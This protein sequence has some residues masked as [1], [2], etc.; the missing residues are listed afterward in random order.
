MEQYEE[1]QEN[2]EMHLPYWQ[3]RSYRSYKQIKVLQPKLDT[4]I[5]DYI[6]IKI[7]EQERKLVGGAL[8]LKKKLKAID[9]LPHNGIMSDMVSLVNKRSTRKTNSN[10]VVP[11]GVTTSDA[12]PGWISGSMSQQELV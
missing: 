5:E 11:G 7:D 9:E 2:R 1:E 12:N 3:R 4:P 6:K 8:Q 10:S